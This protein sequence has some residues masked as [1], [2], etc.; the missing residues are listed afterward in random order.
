MKCHSCGGDVRAFMSFG[1]LPLGN[2]FLKEHQF[3]I[4]KRYKLELGFCSDCTLVQ[5]TSPP[6]LEDLASDYKSYAYIP[7][8]ETLRSHYEAMAKEIIDTTKLGPKSFAVDIGSNNGMLLQFLKKMTGCRILGVEPAE[9][10]SQIA[11]DSGVP[12]LTSFFDNR[13]AS[14][15]SH[16]L[17]MADLVLCTQVLQHIPDIN[18]FMKSLKGIL[19]PNGIFMV[20]GRY[21]GSTLQTRS[22]DTIY[23]EMI[24]FFTMSSL[25]SV[26]TSSDIYPFKA[27]TNEIYGGSLR[28]YATNSP[29][30]APANVAL[31]SLEKKQGLAR[32][33]TYEGFATEVNRIKKVLATLVKS[34]KTDGRSIA[35]YGAPST[36]ATLLNYCGIGKDQ[37]DYIV[38][39]SELKQGLYTPGTHIRIVPQ[40]ALRERPPDYL[41]LLAWRLKDEILEKVNDQRI[42]GMKVIVPLPVPKVI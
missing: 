28:V 23:H 16:D 39:D 24:Y 5:Q 21:F 31:L 8:G 20:E 19:K 29:K 40:I 33:K 15:I 4:E 35:G 18:A 13:V 41:L 10:I 1:N 11:R 34:I 2:A 30:K 36:S 12:T 37:I 27:M 26:L 7:F 32:F 22:F 42:R 25:Q 17:G 6:P 38:D 3:A 9:R 14:R